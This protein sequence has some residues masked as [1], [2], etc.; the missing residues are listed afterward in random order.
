[1]KK[2]DLFEL[3]IIDMGVDGEG[4]G[5]YEDDLLCKGCHHR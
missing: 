1:M 5:K 3:S 2:N 4:I